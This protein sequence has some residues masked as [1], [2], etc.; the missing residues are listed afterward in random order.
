MS[1]L[2][3]SPQNDAGVGTEHTECIVIGAPPFDH[4]FEKIFVTLY[5]NFDITQNSWVND[6]DFRALRDRFEVR[7]G[8]Q[9]HIENVFYFERDSQRD[10]RGN[11]PAEL[12]NLPDLDDL[13]DLAET[14]LFDE[15]DADG[16]KTAQTKS[17]E[18]TRADSVVHQASAVK[19]SFS[20][21]SINKNINNS[22]L[23][24]Q[25]SL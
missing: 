4:D 8:E 24:V 21:F 10:D 14:D 3:D 6:P 11:E 1:L 18:V 23:I 25:F 2:S 20:F 9:E 15:W 13:A 22:M 17:S 19:I 16:C 5:D 7:I 12:A